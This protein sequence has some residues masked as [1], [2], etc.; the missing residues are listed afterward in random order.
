MLK[1]ILF[2]LKANL[3]L[4]FIIKII[5]TNYLSKKIHIKNKIAFKNFKK[6][7][8]NKQLNY[9]WF[10]K[11]IP[12]I[13]YFIENKKDK[14]ILEIGSYEG[15]SSCFFL[16]YYAKSYLVC[17]DPFIE[18]NEEYY[19]QN[20]SITEKNFDYNLK[21]YSSRF[22]KIRLKSEDF[23]KDLPIEEKFDI[24]FIDGEHNADVVYFDAI[25]SWKHLKKGGYLIFD[26]FFCDEFKN[27][28]NNPIIGIKKFTEKCSDFKIVAL[29]SQLIL[30]KIS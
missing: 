13:V 26:D 16:D 24:I 30:K 1:K 15:L 28:N 2:I 3:N 18:P 22:K 17:V 6:K 9:F 25:N 19:N 23:F 27:K 4:I 5:T 20:F 29:Y 11:N 12:F 7:I 21:K 10:L 8:T 14:K